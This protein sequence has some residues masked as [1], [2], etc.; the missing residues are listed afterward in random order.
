MT[1]I[2]RRDYYKK[3]YKYSKG[4]S[5]DIS[6]LEEGMEIIAVCQRAIYFT[7]HPEMSDI[8]EGLLQYSIWMEKEI[9]HH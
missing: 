7:S 8:A 9:C 3:Y 4:T 5:T 6:S 2:M 1:D